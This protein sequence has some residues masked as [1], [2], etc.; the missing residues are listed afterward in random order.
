MTKT[1]QEIVDLL[2]DYVYIEIV[3]YGL[4][5]NPNGF[6]FEVSDFYFDEEDTK[7][8]KEAAT[9]LNELLE[10]LSPAEEKELRKIV[11]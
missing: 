3:S 6:C 9:R 7:E 11:F 2:E 8:Y 10:S 1:V 4:V 5:P